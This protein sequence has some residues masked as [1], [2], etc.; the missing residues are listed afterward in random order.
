MKFSSFLILA[1]FIC[2]LL[3]AGSLAL[4]DGTNTITIEGG[5]WGHGVGMSQYGAYGRALPVNQGGGGQTAAEIL[6]FY[7]PNTS[8][9]QDENVPD[10]IR[11]HLFSGLGATFT[12]SGPIDIKNGND[13][14]FASLTEGTELTFGY[15]QNEF[16]ITNTQGVDIC[17]DDSGETPVNR[18]EVEPIYIELSENE[19]IQTDVISQFTNISTSGNSYQW[20][21]LTVRKRTFAG[22]GI[23]VLLENLPMDKYLYGLAE[24]PASWPDAAL[25]TQAIAGRT[26]AYQRVLSRR[27]NAN[28]TVPW[29]VYST[30]NDQHYTGYSNESGAY[31]PNWQSA[32]DVTS[33]NVL[34]INQSPIIAYYSSSNGGATAAGS[35]VFCTSANFPCANISYLQAQPDAFDSSG[36]PYG[37]WSRSYSGQELGR[38]VAD[39]LG[40]IGHVTALSI[41]GDVD[42]YGRTDHADITIYGTSG[43]KV[44]KG[45]SFM[46]LVNSG[47]SSEGR[48]KSEQILSTLYFVPNF[49][50]PDNRVHQDY[51]NLLPAGWIGTESRDD[52][53]TATVAADFNGDNAIDFTV[54]VSGENIGS[55]SD[56]GLIH[57]I[58][59]GNGGIG[60]NETIYQGEDG[61][62]GVPESGDEFGAALTSAD[63][64]GDGFDDLAVGSP[65][66]EI[67][68]FD[69]AG[70]V[71][72]AYGSATGLGNQQIFHQN[73][74]GIGGAAAAGDRFGSSLA[75]GDINA[76]GFDDLI[77]GVP[78]EY[79]CWPRVCGAVG[80]INIIY[81]SAN[82]LT[83]AN[84]HYFTQNSRGIG[85]ISAVGDQFG[86]SVASGDIDN[87]GFDDVIIGVPGD[88]RCWRRVCGAVGAINIM[89]GTG[90]GLSAANDHY[91]T[92]N[93]SGV[94][95]VSGVGDEFGAFVTTSDINDDGFSD[96]IIGTPG[97]RISSRNNAGAV[98]VLYGTNNGTTT[99]NDTF[100]YVSQSLFTGSSQS[101]ARFGT[102]VTVID[103][104][105]IIGAPG[106]TINGA[107]AAGAIYYLRD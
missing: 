55:I 4:A 90:N 93:S 64:N 74:G 17:I 11:V 28:W 98:H 10:D 9:T 69:N 83:S 36:N 26:Y 20:G 7:Y 104:D 58:Y 100:L 62:P 47:L 48:D 3:S 77:I 40:S 105:L 21:S 70:M 97:E 67:G 78:G 46:S 5:G 60:V 49:S 16:T 103:N 30:V 50:L 87:D 12:T 52:F 42:P 34:L 22:G 96:V 6:E 84:D 61:W 8:L 1:S 65:G 19:P 95:G 107:T 23:Y 66:D 76:D 85:G 45:D 59:G 92:Q 37:T 24:V 101:N 72:V 63:F 25:E 54:G 94:D 51:D 99:A 39:S 14:T 71:T 33:Q 35:Y 53:G 27:G 44:T 41:S 56:A 75:T 32:V 106:T 89:Y 18:C 68:G 86:A 13:E 81:G 43:T 91:F 57:T 2:A 31:A 38:W 88:Y 29:D 73:T 15:G 79:R 82:G 80:G 102:S